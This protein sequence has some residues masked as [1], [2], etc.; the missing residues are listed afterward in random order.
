M[1]KRLVFSECEHD[2]DL[3]RYKGDI[4]KSG[5]LILDATID[6]ESE[7]CDIVIDCEDWEQFKNKF[8]MTES[9]DFRIL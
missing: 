2:G 3:E 1:R 9:S 6:Y 7:E 4:A 8:S 5:G